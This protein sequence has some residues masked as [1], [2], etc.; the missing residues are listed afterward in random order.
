MKSSKS[1]FTLIELLVVIAIIAILAA[2]LFPVLSQARVAAKT[3]V[4]LSNT[5]QIGLASQMYMDDNDQVFYPRFHGVQVA[6]RKSWK[7]IVY[8]YIKNEGIF[9]DPVNRLAQ[10]PDE[11]GQ[12]GPINQGV[13]AKPIFPRGYF[14]YQAFHKAG[15]WSGNG[16]SLSQINEPASA[17]VISENKD[18]FVDY[19]P[20]ME[21]FIPGENGWTTYNW[22]GGKRDD[23][24]LM[25]VYADSHAKMTPLIETCRQETGKENMWQYDVATLANFNIEG[26]PA[27]LSWMDT[28][29]RTYKAKR[30]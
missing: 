12:P 29:C 16:Y 4:A 30:P 26:N 2:I 13:P 20:W 19:G 11:F 27:N 23:R 22:G 21:Y 18:R 15:T 24:M 7:H 14:F 25:I 5:K 9:K 28:M 17:I 8:P 3:T 1:A 10:F 6:E